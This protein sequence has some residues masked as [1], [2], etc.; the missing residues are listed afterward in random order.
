MQLRTLR[1][2]RGWS[3]DDLAGRAG[4]GRSTLQRLELARIDMNINHIEALADAF[5]MPW[6]ELLRFLDNRPPRQDVEPSA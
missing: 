3:Q 5:E 1:N 6:I 4:V 2:A